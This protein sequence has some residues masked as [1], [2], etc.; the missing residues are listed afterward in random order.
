MGVYIWRYGVVGAGCMEPHIMEYP[1]YLKH[2]N[3]T[4]MGSPTDH[5]IVFGFCAYL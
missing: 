5:L 3:L 2:I 1:P 4:L